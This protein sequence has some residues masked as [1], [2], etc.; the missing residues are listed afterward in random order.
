[1]NR[2]SKKEQCIKALLVLKYALHTRGGAHLTSGA[3]GRL[4]NA[5]PSVLLV[6]STLIAALIL[7]QARHTITGSHGTA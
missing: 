7:F 3:R 6:A 1:M 5:A 2:T 4:L